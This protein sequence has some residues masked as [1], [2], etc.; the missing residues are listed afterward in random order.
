VIKQQTG[1]RAPKRF[2]AWSYSRWTDYENCPRQA[3]FKHLDKLPEVKGKAL[4]RGSQIHTEGENF[5]IRKTRGVPTSYVAFKTQ[6]ETIRRRG[7]IAEGSWTFTRDWEL[8]EWNDWDAAWVRMKI[9]AHY[10]D[11]NG[12]L[13]V[14]DF[15][16]GKVR[17][18]NVPQLELY[19]LG[20]LLRYPEVQTVRAEFWYL[21]AG[22][23]HALVFKREEVETLRAEWLRRTK[24]MLTDTRFKPK[25]GY[26]CKWCSFSKTK[27]GPCEF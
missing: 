23:S 6:L 24:P 13:R 1:R 21:D 3:R 16:T 10:V 14:I 26:A 12:A 5:L 15:K 2:T 27:G 17:D 7:A 22:E 19:G 20:G 25:P 8:T 11:G 4:E 9:D 18:S